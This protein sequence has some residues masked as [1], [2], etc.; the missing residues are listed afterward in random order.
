MFDSNILFEYAKISNFSFFS[1]TPLKYRSISLNC[2]CCC[3]CFLS[4]RILFDYIYST[5]KHI[6]NYSDYIRFHFNRLLKSVLPKIVANL[7][8]FSSHFFSLFSNSTSLK[9][10]FIIIIILLVLLVVAFRYLLYNSSSYR[11]LNI[12]L[13]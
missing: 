2:I 4:S 5:L 7:M 12:W 10:W 11:I 13:E 3:C 1:S 8:Y 6:D 9:E